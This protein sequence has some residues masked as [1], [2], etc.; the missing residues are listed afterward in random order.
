MYIILIAQLDDL[1][2]QNM[3]GTD[4]QFLSR[5][6]DK[7]PTTVRKLIIYLSQRLK[8]AVTQIKTALFK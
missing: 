8:V 3:F 2:T 5:I 4:S 7:V 6:K 1:E